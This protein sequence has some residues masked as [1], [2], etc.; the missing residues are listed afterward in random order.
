MRLDEPDTYA[1]F[2]E[3]LKEA[4]ALFPSDNATEKEIMA[5][6]IAYNKASIIESDWFQRRCMSTG[7]FQI[8]RLGGRAA[9]DSLEAKYSTEGHDTSFNYYLPGEE[10]N[11]SKGSLWRFC[12]RFNV[13]LS[14]E[15]YKSL[16]K[17]G[18]INSSSKDNSTVSALLERIDEAV[19]EMKNVEKRY[20]GNSYGLQFG[21][22]FWDDGKVTFHARWAGSGDRDGIMADSAEE[23]LEML[24]GKG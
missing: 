12:S 2:M 6:K 23:L 8:P 21:V 5:F 15:M 3:L 20:E 9:L 19:K 18:N 4:M 16:A 10:A 1:K 22:K 17:F 11:N 7:W 13:L 24:M 14:P